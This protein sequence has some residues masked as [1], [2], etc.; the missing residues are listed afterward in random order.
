MLKSKGEY[1]LISKSL[2]YKLSYIVYI[3]SY[4]YPF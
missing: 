2:W 1:I 4:S 3:F